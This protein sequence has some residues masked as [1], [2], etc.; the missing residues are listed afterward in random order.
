MYEAFPRLRAALTACD[1]SL[2]S[3]RR[4]N[5]TA[6]SK[7]TSI[8]VTTY[9]LGRFS[10]QTTPLAFLIIIIIIIIIIILF[11]QKQYGMTIK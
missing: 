1:P 6:S 2:N 5:T 11:A 4:A 10:I 7:H 8:L 9:L 3:L